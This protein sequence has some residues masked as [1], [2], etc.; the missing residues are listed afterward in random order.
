M[1]FRLSNLFSARVT[2]EIHWWKMSLHLTEITAVHKFS[3]TAISMDRVASESSIKKLINL[4]KKLDVDRTE[5]NLTRNSGQPFCYN[6]N[7]D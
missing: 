2:G 7:E 4:N 5:E 6:G 1:A 3:S